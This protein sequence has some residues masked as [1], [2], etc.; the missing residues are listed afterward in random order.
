M[1]LPVGRACQS[2]FFVDTMAIPPL[3]SRLANHDSPRLDD[4]QRT[5]L[6][7][8][9]TVS[10]GYEGLKHCSNH[11]PKAGAELR[12]QVVPK[13]QPMLSPR[14]MA[15]SYGYTRNVV[16]LRRILSIRR[17]VDYA[18]IKGKRAAN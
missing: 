10:M 5:V 13:I 3:S 7:T 11:I 9:P 14:H 6:G 17:L 15:C 12:T 1:L 2:V 4:I 18:S 16:Y 8:A